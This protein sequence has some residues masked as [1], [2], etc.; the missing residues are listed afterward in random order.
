V[1][2]LLDVGTLQQLMDALGR[3]ANGP[4]DIYLT[5]GATAIVLGF[6]PT[7]LDVDLKL[8]PEAAGIFEAIRDLKD[9][10]RVNIELAAP[11]QFIPPLPGWKERSV[12]IASHGPLRFFHYDYYAQALAKIERGHAQD[13]A[14]VAAFFLR[15]LVDPVKLRELFAAIEPALVRYPAIDAAAFRA[16]VEATLVAL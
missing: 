6:R 15:G 9:Q 1:R 5:G 14:D 3:A 10:L 8:D 12:F 7:T 2:N 16:R 13:V 11:D 4:G